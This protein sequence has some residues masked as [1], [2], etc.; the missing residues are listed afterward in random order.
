MKN[1]Y[2]LPLIT[3]A[4]E[5]LQGA[6]IFTRL[7]LRIIWSESVKATSGKLPLTPLQA[8]M[9]SNL[10]MPFGLTCALALFQYLANDVLRDMLNKFV[11]VFLDNILIFS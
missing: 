2:P 9:R 4:F 5:L 7:N 10:V 3:S 8:T 11:F 1:H 6:T